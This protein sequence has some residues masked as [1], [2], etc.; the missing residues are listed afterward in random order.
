MK[1]RSISMAVVA[2]ALA[3]TSG[4]AEKSQT[5]SL[6]SDSGNGSIVIWSNL[7]NEIGVLEEYAQK[8]SEQTGSTATVLRETPDLQQFSQASKSEGGPDGIYGIANDQLASYVSAGLAQV[9]PEELYSDADYADA[10]VRACYADGVRYGVPIAVETI[11][12]FYNT[13]K[14]KEAPKTWEEMIEAAKNNGGLKFEA[15][16]IYYDVGFLRA[17]DSYIFPYADGGY[18]TGDIGFGNSGAIEAYEYL[19]SLA[20]LGFAGA[21]IT[22]DIAKGSFQNGETAFYIGGPWDV[23]GLKAAGTAFGIAKMPTLN[24]KDFVTPVGTQV[25]FVS[26]K[27]KNQKLVYDFFRYLQENAA[28][29][30]YQAG[31]RIPALL[32]AQNSIEADD[33]TRAFIE[34]IAA[35]EPLPTVAELGQVWTPYSDNMKLMFTGQISPSEAAENIEAQVR[36]GIELMNSGK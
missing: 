23:E 5:L 9:V 3:A 28:E 7:E 30:L 11:T 27:S 10:A 2:M 13:D 4:C 19:N 24:G 29:A 35:G 18:D 6:P 25:G 17:F 8:W 36:E 14:I 16:S 34:Q 33:D 21:D 32:S 15:T 31:G 22:S 26:T 12:L 1:R 20:A